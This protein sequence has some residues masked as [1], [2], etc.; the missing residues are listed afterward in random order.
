MYF[1]RKSLDDLMC[2]VRK[3]I[4]K[5]MLFLFVGLVVGFGYFG[6]KIY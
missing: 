1:K 4:Y 2:R 6:Y 5:I 3:I